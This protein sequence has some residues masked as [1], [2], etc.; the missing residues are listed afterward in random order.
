MLNFRGSEEILR[1]LSFLRYQ[2]GKRIIETSQTISQRD[3]IG[4]FRWMIERHQEEISC[5]APSS[6]D[7]WDPKILPYERNNC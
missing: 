3:V 2:G 1:E 6:P 7:S 5:F 4:C